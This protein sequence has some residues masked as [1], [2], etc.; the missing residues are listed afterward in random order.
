MAKLRRRNPDVTTLAALGIAL[1]ALVKLDPAKIAGDLAGAA[2]KY[3][4]DNLPLV[5]DALM[6]RGQ[7]WQFASVSYSAWIRSGDEQYVSFTLNHRGPAG[8]YLVG[9]MLINDLIDRGVAWDINTAVSVGNDANWVGYPIVLRRPAYG[10][11]SYEMRLYVR[12]AAYMLAVEHQVGRVQV[13]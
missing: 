2:G 6:G 7:T 4:G 10:V 1:F 3:V 9:A 8:S 12:Q 13:V 5:G 11:G